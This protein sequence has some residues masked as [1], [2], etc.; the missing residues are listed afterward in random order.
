M[1]H[2]EKLTGDAR[3]LSEAVRV[4]DSDEGRARVKDYLKSRPFPHF[5]AAPNQPGCLVKIDADGTRTVGR[6][7]SREFVPNPE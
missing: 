1:S 5:E 2:P 3:R 4:A 6:F 7:V